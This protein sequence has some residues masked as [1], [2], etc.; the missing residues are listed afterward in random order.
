MNI[1]SKLDRESVLHSKVNKVNMMVSLKAPEVDPNKKRNPLSICA[2]LDRSGSM[3]GPKLEHV[4]K[5]MYKLIDHLTED[6]GLAVVFF[7]DRVSHIEFKKMNSA[8][9]ESVKKQIARVE[10]GNSTDIGSALLKAIELFKSYEGAVNS[11]ERIMLLTDGQA[12][13][14]AQHY[15]QFVPILQKRRA[16]V[17]VS[18]FGYGAQFN[19]ELLKELAKEG[20]GSNYFIESPDSVA[21]VFAVELG[22]LLTCY[23][24]TISI[25]INPHKGAKVA[26]VLNDF[27]VTT[28]QNDDGDPITVI[29][30]DDIYC[31]ENRKILIRLECEKRP[32]ALP[33]STTVADLKVSYRTVED[34]KDQTGEIK[35]KI[36]FVK[37]EDEVTKEPDKEVAEQVAILEAANIQI[38]AKKLADAGDWN[39]ARDLYSVGISNL[40]SVGT[41]AAV[42][43]ASTMDNLQKDFNESYVAGGLKAKSAYSVS[44]SALSGRLCRSVGNSA[45]MSAGTMN[46]VTAGLVKSFE[47]D[48]SPDILSALSPD[49]TGANAVPQDSAKPKYYG[50]TKQAK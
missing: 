3:A 49:P 47:D 46:F 23:A 27:D 38:E 28:K 45:D 15:E 25:E 19:E 43:Y 7:D 24:Q 11:V 50:K 10:P 18:C 36:S 35:A 48:S 2:V 41:D 42:C 6:D 29:D 39:G 34:S 12:N 44:T 14:G 22:G 17:S 21:K 13:I 16:G 32:Q 5:S 9:K 31:G 26:D 8:A 33:R 1:T 30:I 4:K 37:T 20:K 40:R